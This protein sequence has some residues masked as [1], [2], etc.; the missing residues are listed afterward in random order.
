MD[1]IYHYPVMYREVLELLDISKRH[2]VVDCTVG[3][4]SHAACMLEAMPQDGR[5]IGIDKD[6]ES[7]G[8][9]ASRLKDYQGRFTLAKSDFSDLDK[10]LNGLKV[11]KVD[12]FLFDLGISTY[13]LSNPDRGFSFLK[14]G[15]LDMR[16]DREAF[17][18][19][20][21]LVSN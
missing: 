14:E 3:I 20:S 6:E 1:N 5:L 12:A 15:P 17:L 21:D 11:D 7:L 18:S 9:A 2:V 13:Q 4:A 16:M 10:V 8:V 19:A